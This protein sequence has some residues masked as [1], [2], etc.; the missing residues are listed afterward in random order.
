MD[1]FVGNICITS[2]E[3]SIDDD[4]AMSIDDDNAMSTDTPDDLN[5]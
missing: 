2:E 1:S 4:D 3:L 5:K